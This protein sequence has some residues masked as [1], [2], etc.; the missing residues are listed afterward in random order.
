MMRLLQK[1]LPIN[2][3]NPYAATKAAGEFILK[4]LANTKGY[5]QFAITRCSNNYG[6]LQDDSK[7]VPAC[8]KQFIVYGDKIG[9]YGKGE[10]IRDWI[11]VEDHCI[12]VHLIA[13]KLLTSDVKEPMIYNIGGIN[14][15]SNTEMVWSICETLSI[16]K[17]E[18][19]DYID[20]PRGKAHDFR[21]A[22][23][24][25]K[26]Q[27][28]FGWFPKRTKDFDQALKETADWYCGKNKKENH[29]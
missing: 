9:V 19:I 23:N 16:D 11:H 7:F 24:S 28:D 6:R 21:Y 26:M 17:D 3:R 8:M 20:D 12:A 2:P 22:I 10:Q 25:T 5:T 27:R 14:E 13:R 1:S 18:A 15:L 29:E 4:G